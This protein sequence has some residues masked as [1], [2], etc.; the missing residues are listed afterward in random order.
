MSNCRACTFITEDEVSICPNCGAIIKDESLVES[1][2]RKLTPEM[3]LMRKRLEYFLWLLGIISPIVV[4]IVLRSY[5]VGLYISVV[6]PSLPFICLALIC[7]FSTTI[8][9]QKATGALISALL[10]YF[11]TSVP[12][13]IV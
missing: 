9:I 10:L 5:G 2:S 11:V 7:K 3:I 12:T 8:S 4:S 13:L 6:L 1:T